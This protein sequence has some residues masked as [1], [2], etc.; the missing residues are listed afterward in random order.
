ML[1]QSYQYPNLS[2]GTD[3]VG[4]QLRENK[5]CPFSGVTSS[6]RVGRMVPE[7]DAGSL[8]DGAGKRRW[9]FGG[10]C[11]KATLGV[12]RTVPER[13]AGSLEDGAGKRCWEFGGRCWEAMLGVWTYHCVGPAGQSP[14]RSCLQVPVHHDASGNCK[15]QP[16]SLRARSLWAVI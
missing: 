3:S 6:G 15:L 11:R 10:R 7:S 1:P 14:S 5:V 8:E 9:E 4:G 13:D 2:E 12:W 16:P